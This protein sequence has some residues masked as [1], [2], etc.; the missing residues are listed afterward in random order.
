MEP[1]CDSSEFRLVNVLRKSFDIVGDLPEDDNNGG[2]R[3]SV[4]GIIS[5]SAA[6]FAIPSGQTAVAIQTEKQIR[7]RHRRLLNPVLLERPPYVETEDVEP[8]ESGQ[9]CEM[10]SHGWKKKGETFFWSKAWHWICAGLVIY[11]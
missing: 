5:E 2:N 4:Q 8:R 10:H 3:P 9:K 6:Q 1:T 7:K 11:T